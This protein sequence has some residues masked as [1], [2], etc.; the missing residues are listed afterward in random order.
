MAVY[1]FFCF[2]EF[3]KGIETH[4][5]ANRLTQIEEVRP[6]LDGLKTNKRLPL[7]RSLSSDR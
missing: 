6:L 3:S 2:E 7:P 5:I 1:F 4:P